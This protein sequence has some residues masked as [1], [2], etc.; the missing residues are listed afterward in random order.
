M[1]ISVIT[2]ISHL[3]QERFRA[4]IF[5]ITPEKSPSLSTFCQKV[6]Q[7]SDGKYLD[8]LEYFIQS[9]SLSEKI[10]SFDPEKLRGLLIEQSHGQSLLVVDCADFL[11]DT[12]RKSERQDFF[13]LIANQWD[14]YKEGMKAKLVFALQ[15][16]YEIETLKI[17]DS[18][19]QSRVYRL[20]DFNDIG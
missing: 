5:H 1:A 7:K 2:L 16:S 10:D 15:T 18:Q 20:T 3:E 14:G 17:Y 12:W 11:L 9:P 4:A 13:R 8:L 19:N 6:C